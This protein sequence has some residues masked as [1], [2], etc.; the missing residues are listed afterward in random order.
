[1]LQ[2][3]YLSTVLHKPLHAANRS[4][5]RTAMEYEQDALLGIGEKS[6][7]LP[8][9]EHKTAVSFGLGSLKLHFFV[10]KQLL[11][12]DFLVSISVALRIE[13]HLL[14]C[15]LLPPKYFVHSQIEKAD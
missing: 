13:M 11:P 12:S 7:E 2:N 9:P 10:A 3:Q 1:M 8:L 5:S 15:L 14:R 6:A 4:D